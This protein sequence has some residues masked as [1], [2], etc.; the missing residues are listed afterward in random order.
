MSSIESVLSENRVFAPTPAFKQ[1]ATVSGLAAYQSL[2]KQAEQDYT[3]F[4]ANLARTELDWHKPFTQ[5]LDESKAPFYRW[6]HDGELNAS[7]NCI[8]RHLSTKGDKIAIIFEADDGSVTQLTYKQLHQRVCRFANALKDQGIA[9]GDRVIIYLPMGIEAVIAMQ[10]C[11]RIGAIHSVVFGGFSSKSLHE[12]ITDVGAKLVITAD[13]GMRGGKAVVLKTAVDEALALGGCEAVTKVIVCQRT[14]SEVAWIN[15]R[16]LWWHELE[17]KASDVCEPTWV[18]AEHPL[19]I[20]YTS[21]S[22]PPLNAPHKGMF[23]APRPDV[24]PYLAISGTASPTP[25]SNG[26]KNGVCVP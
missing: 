21:G 6:F 10:A 19:F 2:C 9:L 26:F 14:K 3:G 20:L 7:Y 17:I 23:N 4:W 25:C 18:N 8:D 1:N 15:G 11:A 13:A 22:T 5:I 16:D 12:R 24:I